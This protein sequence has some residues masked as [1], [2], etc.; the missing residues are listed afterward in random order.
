MYKIIYNKTTNNIIESIGVD[1]S[2]DVYYSLYSDEFKNDIDE[3]ITP[4]RLK[5]LDDYKIIDGEIIKKTDDEIKH[6]SFY[7]KEFNNEELL[8]MKLQPTYSEVR[9]AKNTIDILSVLLE[10]L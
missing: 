4:N 9:T 10:V 3:L 6:T 7:K 5:N 8:L 2:I 1:Q